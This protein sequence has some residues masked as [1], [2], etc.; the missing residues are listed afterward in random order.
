MRIYRRGKVYWCQYQGRRTSLRCTDRKAAELAAAKLQRVAADPAYAAAHTVTV[1]DALQSYLESL[2]SRPRPPTPP[3][4]DMLRLHCG[5]FVR[6]LGADRLLSEVDARTV[7]AYIATRRS[8]TIGKRQPRPVSANTV[9]KE[10]GTLRQV[11]TLALRRGDYHLPLERV[12]PARYATEY[13][14]LTRRLDAAQVPRLLAELS[15]A[16]A[17]ICAYV[18]GLGADAC[19]VWRAVPDDFELESESPTVLVRGTKTRHRWARVPVLPWF[20]AWVDQAYAYIAEHR[21]FPSW[22]NSTRD[23]A[24]ACRKAQLPR[25]TLRDLRRTHGH[26]L[27]ANGVRPDLIGGM[28]RQADSRMAELVYAQLTPEL[29]A[30]LIAAGTQTVQPGAADIEE[31]NKSE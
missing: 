13:V 21:I 17:A 11:L 4:V 19:A 30:T 27:R 18:V 28:L 16:R 20:T 2:A 24:L 23:L 8:E 22:S 29:L 5:H 12:L 25:V 15:P 6:L 1:A 31:P 10:L 14:P 9:S 7:D 3:T 26:I